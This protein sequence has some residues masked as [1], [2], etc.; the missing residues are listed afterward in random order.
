MSVTLTE[1]KT[2]VCRWG[3]KTTHSQ[4]FVC[5]GFIP[6]RTRQH[7]ALGRARNSVLHSL[8]NRGQFRCGDSAIGGPRHFALAHARLC[9]SM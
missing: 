9:N 7:E 2:A 3:A 5:V 1:M 8:P 6:C 4:T